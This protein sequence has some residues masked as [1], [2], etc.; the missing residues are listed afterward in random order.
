MCDTSFATRKQLEQ[1]EMTH[2]NV[3]AETEDPEAAPKVLFYCDACDYSGGSQRGLNVHKAVT[4]R[5]K[6]PGQVQG[7]ANMKSHKK[8]II[9][10]LEASEEK[11]LESEA[12]NSAKKTEKKRII[13][14]D[15]WITLADGHE[16]VRA[17][18][19]ILTLVLASTF[20]RTSIADPG[21]L[22][23]IPVRIFPSRIPDSESKKIQN[24][25]PHQSI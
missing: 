10:N 13:K 23:R 18:L 22:S 12:G 19:N 3:S 5:D 17:C 2:Q 4:H 14:R 9:P 21:C 6:T 15:M 1:H 16:Q 24:P 11:P 25:D 20:Y 8:K 7:Q